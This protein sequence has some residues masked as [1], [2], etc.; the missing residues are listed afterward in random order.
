MLSGTAHCAGVKNM[1]EMWT[2]GGLQTTGRVTDDFWKYDGSMWECVRPDHTDVPEP[3]MYATLAPLK[4]GGLL[5]TGGW[6]PREKGSGGVFYDDLWIFNAS[7]SGWHQSAQ[8]FPDGPVSRHSAVMLED[9]RVLVHTFRCKDEVLLYDPVDDTLVSQPTS[10]DAPN[11][12]SMQAY[13]SVGSA[14]VLVG[15][16]TNDQS[17]SD[18][19][20]VLDTN[21]WTWHRSFCPFSPRASS[22]M[23]AISFDKCVLFGGAS[24]DGAYEGGRGLDPKNDVYV[25]TL[26]DGRSIDWKRAESF[27]QVR[28]A[29]RVAATMWAQDT[30]VM[31]TGGWD[32]KTKRTFSDLWKIEVSKD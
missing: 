15:G 27:H 17:M 2:F 20:Y 14:V 31:L 25:G 10:G 8:T 30:H 28:P 16:T 11:A 13:A 22:S 7:T 12:L 6:D 32:P 19:A 23:D 1:G 24:I 4:D 21:T 18:S 29:S 26:T 3:R 9:G 5:L